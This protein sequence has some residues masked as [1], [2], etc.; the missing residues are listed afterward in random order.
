MANR[1]TLGNIS[2]LFL[3]A[4]TGRRLANMETDQVR[5][6]LGL[7][8]VPFEGDRLNLQVNSNIKAVGNDGTKEDALY[9]ATI[10][11]HVR[12]S[13]PFEP[14][15]QPEIAAAVWPYLRA[16]LLEHVNRFQIPAPKFPFELDPAQIQ[17]QQ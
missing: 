13:E 11:F 2:E 4:L 5:W 12:L 10:S 9:E 15:Q 7:G 3:V 8:T 6:E 16:G 1:I 14:E 17:Q